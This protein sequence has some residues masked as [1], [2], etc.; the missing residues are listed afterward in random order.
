MRMLL[1]KVSGHHFHVARNR[2]WIAVG[3]L[4]AGDEHG[5]AS[6]HRLRLVG[7]ADLLEDMQRFVGYMAR[8][9]LLVLLRRE[10]E[11][12]AQVV[13]HR[14]A[15]ERPRDLKG[16]REPEPGTAVRRILAD[17]AP[18]EADGA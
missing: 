14:H 12:Y 15:G 18:F 16:A 13:E 3:D 10:H 5:E 17:V 6:G 9:K 4:P 8:R 2:L 1:A 7:E 11:W